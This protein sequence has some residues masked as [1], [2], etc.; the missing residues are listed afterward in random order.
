VKVPDF[1]VTSVL[2]GCVCQPVD[3]SGPN[4]KLATTVLKSGLARNLYAWSVDPAPITVDATEP[5]GAVAIATPVNVS[6]AAMIEMPTT[7]LVRFLNI[8]RPPFDC[9]LLA[10]AERASVSA[11]FAFITS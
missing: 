3:E 2:P 4:V 6:D 5:V 9:G 10:Q 7:H 8:C 11:I 1:T